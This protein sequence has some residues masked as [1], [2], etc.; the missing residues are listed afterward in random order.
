MTSIGVVWVS[1]VF[2]YLLLLIRPQSHSQRMD[3]VFWGVSNRSVPWCAD[4][5]FK[6]FKSCHVKNPHI[7]LHGQAAQ[8]SN[9]SQG[10]V[11]ACSLFCLS[12]GSAE[13]CIARPRNVA[14]QLGCK[15]HG[16]HWSFDSAVA[17]WRFFQSEVGNH[18]KGIAQRDFGHH[19][20][21]GSG[22]GVVSMGYRCGGFR[23]VA[24]V[25]HSCEKL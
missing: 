17:V 22:H 18:F 12:A 9:K 1:S 14:C 24:C 6:H 23:F 4:G 19:E 5:C 25:L 15:W 3:F 20:D 10:R 21:Q 2:Q 8:H 13:V 11:S 7:A 16:R